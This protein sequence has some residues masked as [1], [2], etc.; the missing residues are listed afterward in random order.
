MIVHCSIRPLCVQILFRDSF[1]HFYV[2]HTMQLPLNF[3]MIFTSA[4]SDPTMISGSGMIQCTQVGKVR[5]GNAETV[6][7]AAPRTSIKM[8]E[9][10]LKLDS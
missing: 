7:L 8:N 5:R 1:T 2:L 4:K 3:V 6:E 9:A 10:K